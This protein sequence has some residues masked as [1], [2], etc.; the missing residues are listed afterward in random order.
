MKCL[1]WGQDDQTICSAGAE[2]AVYEWALRDLSRARESVI[3]VPTVI[4]CLVR[5]AHAMKISHTFLPHSP[6]KLIYWRSPAERE[7]FAR[8]SFQKTS[9]KRTTYIGSSLAQNEPP[10][11]PSCESIPTARW[12][13]GAPQALCSRDLTVSSLSTTC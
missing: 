5:M 6:K 3:K 10:L 2:G 12:L 7:P 4:L 1:A 13:D 11:V 9:V 8:T